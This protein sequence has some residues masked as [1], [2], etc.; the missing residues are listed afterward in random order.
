MI[1]GQHICRSRPSRCSASAAPACPRRRRSLAGGRRS[2][3]L[4]R[5]RRGPRASARPK[6]LANLFDLAAVRLV[7]TSRRWCCAR[8]AADP[9]RAAL[10]GR[11]ARSRPGSKSSATSNCFAASAPRVRPRSPLV[12]ITGTNGK[13]HDHGAR[14]RISS[15]RRAAMSQ[16]GGNIGVPIL[17]LEP[18]SPRPHPCRRMLVVPDRSRALASAR[19]SACCSISRPTISTGTARWRITPAVKERLVARADV[20]LVGVDDD[21][22]RGDLAA[23]ELRGHAGDRAS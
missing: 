19:A 12:A 8:R 17:E 10:D 3:C 14:S 4:G 18:P 21:A 5:S 11:H 6:G 13:S 7:A 20:A 1:A 2:R 23:P 9:S 16:M 15:A 22:C